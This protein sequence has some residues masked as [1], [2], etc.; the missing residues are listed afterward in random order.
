VKTHKAKCPS[1]LSPLC[2]SF[3]HHY[4][5]F[6]WYTTQAQAQAHPRYTCFHYYKYQHV[7]LVYTMR[8]SPFWVT[9]NAI[10]IHTLSFVK[11]VAVHISFAK[12]YFTPNTPPIYFISQGA[13]TTLYNWLPVTTCT[14]TKRRKWKLKFSRIVITS[15]T[16]SSEYKLTAEYIFFFYN[17]TSKLTK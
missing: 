6:A 1:I 9:D 13:L 8:K 16:T 10:S 11:D 12:N 7:D 15:I 3:S 17:N 14:F 5:S 2:K 4:V